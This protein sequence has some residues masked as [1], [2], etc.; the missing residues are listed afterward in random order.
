M[1]FLLC[2]E[3]VLKFQALYKGLWSTLSWY[4]YNMKVR[5]LVSVFYT[6]T[7][8]FPAMFLKEAI[9]CQF[10]FWVLGQNS[11]YC[12][13]RDLCLG[14]VFWAIDLCVCFCANTMLFLF[15]WLCTIVWNQVLLYLLHWTFC[16]ELLWLF[17]VFCVSIWILGLLFLSLWRYRLIEY[18]DSFWY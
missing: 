9:F 16:S 3:V 8:N 14:L 17:K 7:S 13:C 1:Y 18:V 12:S 4:W 15:L 2:P 6:W 5:D 11:V 10:V